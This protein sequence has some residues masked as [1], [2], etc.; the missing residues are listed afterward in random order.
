MLIDYYG[1]NEGAFDFL[2]T[3]LSADILG[4]PLPAF[5]IL[6]TAQLSKMS[7]LLLVKVLSVKTWGRKLITAAV[8]RHFKVCFDENETEKY[9]KY[10]EDGSEVWT[11]RQKTLW[12]SLIIDH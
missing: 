4:K 10:K 9:E 5:S 6:S 8:K 1:Y 3:Y 11:D 2:R 12:Q 7:L